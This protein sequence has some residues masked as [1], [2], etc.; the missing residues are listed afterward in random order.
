MLEKST[1][2]LLQADGSNLVLGK[3][4]EAI[5]RKSIHP[6]LVHIGD[7]VYEI[8]SYFF[9]VPIYLTSFT[10]NHLF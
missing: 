3:A 9:N 2:I 8:H 4:G 1:F 10:I 6:P 5:A 7:N